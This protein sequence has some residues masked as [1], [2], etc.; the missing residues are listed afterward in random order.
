MRDGLSCS[1]PDSKL[2]YHC[3]VLLVIRL[4]KKTHTWLEI[5]T[6]ERI[7][8]S[9]KVLSTSLKLIVNIPFDNCVVQ[10]MR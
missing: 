1:E 9:N 2:Q 10:H 8:D 4:I 6:I 3:K 7:Y 5:H